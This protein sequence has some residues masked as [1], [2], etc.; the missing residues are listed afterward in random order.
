MRS[1]ADDRG[2]SV[3]LSI[4]IQATSAASVYL[5]VIHLDECINWDKS[6]ENL[7]CSVCKKKGDAENMLICDECEKAF[8][9]YCHKPKVKRIPD[10]DWFCKV[11][12]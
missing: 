11:R 1:R 9:T 8:H 5:H 12:F 3:I 10:G 2:E 4:F 6:P 7:R